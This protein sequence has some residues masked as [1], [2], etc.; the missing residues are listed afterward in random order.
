MN[1]RRE[2][3]TVLAAQSQHI[4]TFVTTLWMGGVLL[5]FLVIRILGSESAHKVSSWWRAH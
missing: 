3:E 1:T 5:A 2:I 4:W